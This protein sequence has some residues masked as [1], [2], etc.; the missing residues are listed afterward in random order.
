MNKNPT[1]NP[2]I[3]IIVPIFNVE[4]YLEPCLNSIK[5]QTYQNLE[6][7]LINDGSTDNSLNIAQKFL[8]TDSRFKLFSQKNAGLS[9]ARNHGIK[10]ATGKYIT[11]VDSDDTI[12]KN[13]LEMMLRGLQESEADIAV[14]S[15]KE[16]FPNSRVK[17]FNTSYKKQT[18]NTSQALSAMLQ[19]HGFMVSATMKLYPTEYFKKIEFPVGKLHEDVGTTYKL[20]MQAKTIIFLPQELYNYQHHDSSIISTF[21]DKKFDLISLTDQMC[22][23]ID[24]KY[25]NLKNITNERRIRARFSILRQ[26]PSK[27]PEAKELLKYI[28][29]H[30]NYIAK[31]PQATKTDKIALRLALTNLKLFQLTYKLFK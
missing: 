1:N 13:M 25:P 8:D 27:R 24:S 12:E 10:K 21:N 18:Y 14:C 30:R 28:K 31:N 16:V 19:E 9:S 23:D 11:F 15:F 2:L 7:I 4:Q 5:N 17:H 26:I 3:S 29:I 6:I 22:D 20:I